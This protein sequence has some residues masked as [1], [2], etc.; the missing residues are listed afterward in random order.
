MGVIEAYVSAESQNKKGE[1]SCQA[2]MIQ[3]LA[4][5][6]PDKIRETKG[7]VEAMKKIKREVINPVSGDRVNV[8][9]QTAVINGHGSQA[10]LVMGSSVHNAGQ[11]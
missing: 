3:N 9:V 8:S 1:K 2:E 10:S 11:R 7:E 5:R 4:V 6:D